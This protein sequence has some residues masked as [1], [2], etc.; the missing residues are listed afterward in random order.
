MLKMI[1]GFK[2]L[3]QFIFSCPAKPIF[4]ALLD[5]KESR[6]EKVQKTIVVTTKIGMTGKNPNGGS[7]L[8]A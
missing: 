6:K 7:N 4:P 3:L 8:N 1:K 2:A 5:K